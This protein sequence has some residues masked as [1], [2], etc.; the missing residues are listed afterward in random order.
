MTVSFEEYAK[1]NLIGEID[2]K[3]FMEKPEY[4]LGRKMMQ[5]EYESSI[6]Q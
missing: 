1:K 6:K 3:D 5:L 4:A 2:F